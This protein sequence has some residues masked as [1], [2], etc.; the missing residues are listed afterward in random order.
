[1]AFFQKRHSD[2]SYPIVVALRDLET[3]HGE[4]QLGGEVVA[5]EGTLHAP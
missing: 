3:V 4:R 5:V 1:M 2:R